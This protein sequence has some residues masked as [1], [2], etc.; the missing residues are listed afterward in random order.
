MR[1]A[2]S[3][4]KLVRDLAEASTTRYEAILKLYLD[5][6]KGKLRDYSELS[7]SSRTILASALRREGFEELAAGITY[8][9][10]GRKD[11]EFPPEEDLQRFEATVPKVLDP[12]SAAVVLFVLKTGL[13]SFEVLGLTRAQCQRAVQTGTL[14]VLRKGN[15]E[16]NVGMG[17]DALKHL[18]VMLEA[19]RRQP[20]SK[21]PTPVAPLPWDV[22][23]Q[24]LSFK[25]NPKAAYQVLR[26]RVSEASEA[27][28][29]GRRAAHWLRHAFAT[30][31]VRKGA[32]LP[33]V[34][35]QLGHASLE[36]TMRYIHPSL[37]DIAKY[38]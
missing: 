14:R 7:N 15:Y 23:S 25:P 36:T 3:S 19:P 38:V 20:Q 27:A 35:R 26:S 4:R 8:P 33:L 28:N 34:Q 10:K 5:R 13:R 37:A 32:P 30:R 21:G 1:G 16:A 2:G 9:K 18:K 24:L 22:T 12:V 17:K 6:K 31:M 11:V 29:V